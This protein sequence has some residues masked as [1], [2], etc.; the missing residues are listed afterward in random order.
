MTCA[1]WGMTI[2]GLIIIGAAIWP[3]IGGGLSGTT[4]WIVGI[5]SA[6]II[7]LAWTGVECKRCQA[8]G[9]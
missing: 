3:G 2:L 8:A 9:A 5:S 1:N 7:G 4:A 6:L